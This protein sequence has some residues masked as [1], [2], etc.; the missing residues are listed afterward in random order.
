M[1]KTGIDAS[2]AREILVVGALRKSFTVED[3]FLQRLR[4][5]AGGGPPRQLTALDIPGFSV[6]RGE[7]LGILGES[8][9][10]KSTLARVLMGIYEADSGSAQLNGRD[11]VGVGRAERLAA[12]RDMQ[13]IFQDPFG[14][15]DPRMTVRQIIAEPLKIHGIEPEGGREQAMIQALK[16][17]GLEME[18]LDRYPSEFSGGQRQRIGICRALILGPS[19]VI[20]DEAVSALDVSVQAQILELLMGLRARR[21]LSMIFISHDVAVVR[22]ISDRIILLYHGHLVEELPADSLIDGAR[23]PYTR[24]LLD[25]ALFLR[26]GNIRH[27]LEHIPATDNRAAGPEGCCYFAVCPK[28]GEKCLQKPTLVEVAPGHRVACHHG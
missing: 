5:L 15:L 19:L 3:S 17:V 6:G 8:G 12:L 10:G 11:L 24:R 13:M 28:R 1:D 2:P 26:E 16:E 4:R 20:A 21:N 7:T 18:A 25:S 9:S 22:Q 27:A 14:S 23:H